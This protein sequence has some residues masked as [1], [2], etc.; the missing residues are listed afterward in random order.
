MEKMMIQK[1]SDNHQIYHH[2]YPLPIDQIY[3]AMKDPKFISENIFLK[4]KL[5]SIK[6]TDENDL[7]KEGNEIVCEVMGK[8]EIKLVVENVIKKKDYKSF[9]HKC[10]S[11]PPL[12]ASFQLTFHFYWDS[13]NASTVFFIEFVTLDTL[14]KHSLGT[15][16]SSQHSKIFKNLEEVIKNGFTVLSQ[17]E[18]ILINKSMDQVYEY[19]SSNLENLV[20]F[21]GYGENENNITANYTQLTQ[22][23]IIHDNVIKNV[24][25]LKVF[26]DDK[27]NS[28]GF[29]SI[30]LEV[31]ASEKKVPKQKVTI[32]FQQ[33]DSEACMII[34][35]HKILEYVEYSVLL[36]FSKLKQVSLWALKQLFEESN[37]F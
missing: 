1:Q 10:I 37:K 31:V 12:F 11:V 2:V 15:F 3:D 19:F 35:E 20:L 27:S 32:V 8:F 4:S 30:S 28:E 17:S 13:V 26:I 7:D 21:F 18:S 34:F 36:G 6:D 9:T 29:K 16:L 5:I 25:I 14:Y 33:V 23:L 24:L 22:E